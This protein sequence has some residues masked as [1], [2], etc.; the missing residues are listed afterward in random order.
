MLYLKWAETAEERVSTEELRKWLLSQ[1]SQDVNVLF[2]LFSKTYKI[3]GCKELA[4]LLF[5]I[6]CQKVSFE[7]SCP[8]SCPRA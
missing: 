1:N 2:D 6:E 7:S 4:K 5:T 8:Q 3:V